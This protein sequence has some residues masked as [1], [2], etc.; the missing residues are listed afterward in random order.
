MADPRDLKATGNS[1]LA[2]GAGVA[3][4][5][6]VGAAIGVACPFCVVAAPA[7]AG[8][9]IVQRVRAWRQEAA[10]KKEPVTEP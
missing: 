10:D 7:L 9:G 8:L 6:V 3:A 2:T 1:Y 5:G 4:I